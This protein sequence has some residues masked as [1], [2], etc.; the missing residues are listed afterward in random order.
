M[1]QCRTIEWVAGCE[2]VSQTDDSLPK[3]RRSK[4]IFDHSAGLRSMMQAAREPQK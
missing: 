1:I 4:T 3:L 2:A